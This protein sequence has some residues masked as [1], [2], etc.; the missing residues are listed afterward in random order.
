MRNAGEAH[1]FERSPIIRFRVDALDV[2]HG[3][4]KRYGILAGRTRMFYKQDRRLDIL[5]YPIGSASS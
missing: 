4:T 1:E 5:A 3:P 2:A